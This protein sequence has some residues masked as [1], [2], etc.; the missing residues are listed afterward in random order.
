MTLCCLS[1]ST[2]WHKLGFK[3]AAL[4]HERNKLSP[5]QLQMSSCAQ[6]G[7]LCV[8]V[9][10]ADWA[11]GGRHYNRS[12]ERQNDSLGCSALPTHSCLR[13]SA[14]SSSCTARAAPP[15]PPIAAVAATLRSAHTRSGTG[16]AAS[17]AAA[18]SAASSD[19]SGHSSSTSAAA[20]AAY[21]VSA[22]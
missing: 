20:S 17:R 21:S 15:A 9:R 11:T 1:G 18:R 5:T 3:S 8:F 6:S 12:S 7:V 16:V 22:L 2:G 4:C 10:Q 13:P 14:L 19:A